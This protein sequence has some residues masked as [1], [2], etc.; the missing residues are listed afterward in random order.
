[1]VLLSVDV[2][3]AEVSVANLTY[4]MT[5]SEGEVL[6]KRQLLEFTSSGLSHFCASTSGDNTLCSVMLRQFWRHRQETS[7]FYAGRNVGYMNVVEEANTL[8]LNISI[9]GLEDMTIK[10]SKKVSDPFSLNTSSTNMKCV[11]AADFPTYFDSNNAIN[12]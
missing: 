4:S 5:S 12:K 7:D 10:L 11:S 9:Y 3:H 8:A 6:E 1:M 2:H